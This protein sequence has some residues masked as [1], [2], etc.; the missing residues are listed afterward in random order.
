M[1]PRMDY[2]GGVDLVKKKNLLHQM[3]KTSVRRP[4]ALRLD[5]TDDVGVGRVSQ[6]HS[7]SLRNRPKSK[8][9]EI[10]ADK[11]GL[12]RI[13]QLPHWTVTTLWMCWYPRLSIF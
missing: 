8:P 12:C 10:Y 5:G 1:L 11:C 2:E 4:M 9:A 7:R 6:V 3:I 13:A